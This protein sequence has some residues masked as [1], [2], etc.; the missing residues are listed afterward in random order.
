MFIKEPGAS[1]PEGYALALW[2]QFYR[3]YV[4]PRR[5]RKQPPLPTHDS[6]G[7]AIFYPIE[8]DLDPKY[9]EAIE[10]HKLQLKE[11]VRDGIT[12]NVG[13]MKTIP[14]KGFYVLVKREAYGDKR[15]ISL[16]ELRENLAGLTFGKREVLHVSPVTYA[17]SSASIDQVGSDYN[18]FPELFANVVAYLPAAWPRWLKERRLKR[19]KPV[20]D[21]LTEVRA[22]KRTGAA[23]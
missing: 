6:D 20:P 17:S 15:V 16:V 18:P 3:D 5:E 21:W 2:D 8:I 12:A 13:G 9:E 19:W 10:W 4:I 23:G 22:K 7:V 14:A 11:G 1:R